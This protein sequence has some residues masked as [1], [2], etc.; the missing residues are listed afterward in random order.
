[1]MLR[2]ARKRAKQKRL[3]FTLTLADIILPER[4]PILGFTLE[5]AGPDPSK[6]PSL[7]RIVP[8][9]GYVPGNIAIISFRANKIKASAGSAD[10]MAAIARDACQVARWMRKLPKA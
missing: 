3:P 1:M 7:D 8:A 9:R 10:E 5:L 6:S 2:S 4:C